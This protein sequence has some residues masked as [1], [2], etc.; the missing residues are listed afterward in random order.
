MGLVPLQ[1]K[2]VGVFPITLEELKKVL[3]IPHLIPFF[4]FCPFLKLLLKHCTPQSQEAEAFLK[5]QLGIAFSCKK[6]HN[7]LHTMS[8]EIVFV[9]YK[10]GVSQHLL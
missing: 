6:K 4:L 2:L 10:D 5:S 8:Q 1:S 9:S 3:Q 7:I